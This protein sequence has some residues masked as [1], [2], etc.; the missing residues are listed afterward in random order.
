VT[1]RATIASNEGQG[2]GKPTAG[3]TGGRIATVVCGS[4]LALVALVAA[5]LGGTVLGM[6]LNDDGY[7]DLGT[8]RFPHSVDTY[9]MATDGFQADAGLGALYEDL[10][11]TFTPDDPSSEVFIGL[12]E[13]S[14]VREYLDDIEHTVI[15]DSTPDG[16]DQTDHQGGSPAGAPADADVWSAKAS[17]AGEQTLTWTVESGEM[18]AVAMNADGSRALA[19]TVS[20]AGKIGSATLLGTALLLGGLVV[21]V[22]SVIWLIVRPMR[23]ARGRVS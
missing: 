15:H 2:T 12:G 1:D 19:G 22:A 13:E 17:G 21:L 10:R 6:G 23:R 18:V 5:G 3:W 8:D 16:D 20:V 9:A 4:V 14:K 11:I 7:M